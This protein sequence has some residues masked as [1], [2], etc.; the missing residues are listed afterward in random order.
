MSKPIQVGITGGIGSGKSLI[1]KIFG[2]LGIPL[3]DADSRAKMLMTIDK[4]LVQQIKKEF[5]NLSYHPDGSLNKEHLRRTFGQP[6]EVR[7]LNGLVHPRVAED[8][9]KWVEEN[10]K[11]KYV[12]KE[13]ALLIE[14]GSA[15]KLDY[16]IVVFAPKDLRVKRVL[17]RDLLR[18]PQEVESIIN[19]QLSDVEKMEKAD[20][21]IV[22][23]ETRLVIPQVLELHERFNSMN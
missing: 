2:T 23:D 16:L 15:D 3:Y 9:S 17:K 19:N 8:Y 1:C 5:G 22:N 4:I 20:H 14:S 11:H 12:I 6:D 10:R 7:K 13:A 18:T 21:V